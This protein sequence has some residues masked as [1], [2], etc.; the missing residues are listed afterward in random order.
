MTQDQN[1]EQDQSLTRVY[2]HTESLDP[3]Q[4]EDTVA[5]HHYGAILTFSGRV[6]NHNQGKGVFRLVYEAYEPM[7]IKEMNQILQ[8]ADQ[9]FPQTYSVIHHRLGTLELG[10]IAVVV[11]VGSAHRKITFEVCQWVIDEL[12]ARVPIFKHEHRHDGE[13]WVGLG[14]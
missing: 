1:P 4:I 2:L 8:E 13:V 12:K 14:P 11:C 3:R 6:R 5:S 9:K 7:A 10:E